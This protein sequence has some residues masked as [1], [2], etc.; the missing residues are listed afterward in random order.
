MWKSGS[1]EMWK[2]DNVKG[3]NRLLSILIVWGAMGI[4]VAGQIT[5]LADQYL[6][7]PF[8]TN[9]AIA[10]TKTYSPVTLSIRQQWLGMPSAPVYETVT[11]HQSLLDKRQRFN[12]RG[13]L[14]RGENAFG[15]V[16]IG[17]GLFN[18]EYGNIR[19]IGIHTD[20]A[21]HVFLDKGRLSFG[22]APVYHM[23]IIGKS[24]LVR[25]DGDKYDDV[26]DNDPTEVLHFLDVNAGIHYFSRRFFGGVSAIQL[27]DSGVSFGDLSYVTKE[28]LW[29]NPW[30]G[31]SFYAYGGF[32]LA[33]SDQLR[34]EPSVLVRYS[35]KTGP[36]FQVHA[37]LTVFEDY[38][39]GIYWRYNEAMGFF[40]S[41]RTGN[42]IFR[43]QF[44]APAGKNM[45][46]NI[47]NQVLAGYL[48]D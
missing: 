21:Y 43:Y 48:I 12:P 20:Y 24:G 6:I 26:L 40:A 31:R 2:C 34:L 13:F 46:P 28:D 47:A 10:G 30:L 37:S 29:Q 4:P 5:P 25:P 15:K 8:L 23:L 42:L 19:Q 44:E 33:L 38:E 1:V 36:G 3:L 27:F 41:L 18:I 39:A 16:G 17:A 35:A 9:P 11:W 7:N 22:L 14:N 45:I 32:F